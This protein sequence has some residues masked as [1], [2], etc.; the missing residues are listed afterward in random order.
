MLTGSGFGTG[1][2]G[3]QI[4]LVGSTPAKTL[5]FNDTQM[6]LELPPLEHGNHS[7][8]LTVP[9]QGYATLGFVLLYASLVVLS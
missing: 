7:L 6:T 2:P 5:T 9:D 8:K 1:F 4:V 3:E